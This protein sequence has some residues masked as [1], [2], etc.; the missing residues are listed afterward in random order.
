MPEDRKCSVCQGPLSSRN[1][2]GICAKTFECR[3]QQQLRRRGG[4]RVRPPKGDS[5]WLLSPAYEIHEDGSQILDRDGKPIEIV[6]EVAIRVA[7][8]G[9]RRVALTDTER[10][11]VIQQMIKTGWQYREI[12]DHIGTS[13]AK[14]KPMIEAMGYRLIPRRQPGSKT[15]REATEIRPVDS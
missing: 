11:E 12:A 9:T 15:P 8:A 4:R 14:L 1:S 2:S 7:V 5:A 13:P 6:D 3:V 10:R